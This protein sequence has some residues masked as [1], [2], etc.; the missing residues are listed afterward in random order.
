MQSYKDQLTDEEI[1]AIATYERNAWGNN[2]DDL[3]QPV[4]VANLRQTNNQQPTMVNKA[5]AGGFQ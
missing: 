4:E 2:T 5:K 1:A 3:V